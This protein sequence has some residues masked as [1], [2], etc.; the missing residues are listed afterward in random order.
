M[1]KLN[2]VLE[3]LP[4][5]PI[6]LTVSVIASR[7]KLLIIRDLL[8]STKR[9]SELLASLDGVS[10]KVLTST[11]KEMVKQGLV[12]R[13]VYP[14]VPPRVEYSLTPLGF[15]LVP[16]LVALK[17]WGEHFQETMGLESPEA[18]I[19]DIYMGKIYQQLQER[20]IDSCQNFDQVLNTQYNKLFADLKAQDLEKVFDNPNT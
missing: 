7:W 4:H 5:C 16:V 19:N 3:K 6:A 8:V 9:N 13:K 14:E 15:S 12:T 1:S 10:Q 2:S 17:N 20:G 11:L 18:D